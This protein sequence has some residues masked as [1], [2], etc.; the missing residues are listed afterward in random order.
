MIVSPVAVGRRA[1]PT[2]RGTDGES[3]RYASGSSGAS[4]IIYYLRT[5]RF[6][7][8]LTSEGGSALP[9]ADAIRIQEVKSQLLKG[10]CSWTFRS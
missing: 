10:A 3:P 7:L 9:R 1:K 8:C 4:V 2:S 6:G 5:V